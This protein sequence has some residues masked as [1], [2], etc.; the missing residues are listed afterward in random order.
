MSVRDL[1]TRLMDEMRT[2]TNLDW[3]RYRE[4]IHQAYEKASFDDRGT[5][6]A[7]H[8]ALMDTVERQIGPDDLRKLQETRRH[9][10]CYFLITESRVGSNVSRKA[11]KAVTDREIKAGRHVGK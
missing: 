5:L 11:L 3:M 4:E 2:G 8:K 10:Y 1:L 7:I 6:L 9:E